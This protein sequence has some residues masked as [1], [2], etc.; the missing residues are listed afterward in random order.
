[1]QVMNRLVNPSM[2][3]LTLAILGDENV[4]NIKAKELVYIFKTFRRPVIIE[5]AYGNNICKELC[6]E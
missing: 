2:N 4:L 1:M 3:N 6:V 5:C